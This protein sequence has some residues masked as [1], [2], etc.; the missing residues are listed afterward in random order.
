[1]VLKLYILCYPTYPIARNW[2]NPV[3]QIRVG[4][5]SPITVFFC[6]K[7]EEN[8]IQLKQCKNSNEKQ[9][10][11]SKAKKNT[12]NKIKPRQVRG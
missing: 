5:F 9:I 7:K 4:I 3:S 8:T 12:E 11:K 1:V 10:K 2:A 6:E